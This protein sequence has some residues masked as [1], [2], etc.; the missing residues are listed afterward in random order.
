M[1]SQ[2]RRVLRNTVVGSLV[3]LGAHGAQA[4]LVVGVFDPDFGGPLAGTNYSG[5]A[6]FSISQ[7]CL[8]LNLPSIGLFIPSFL[9]CGSGSS[10]MAF[11]GAHVDFTGAET[12]SVDFLASAND[13]L[14]MYV[15][16]HQVIGVWSKVIGPATST[17]PGNE[18]FDLLF[19][20]LFPPHGNIFPT[21]FDGDL[22][23]FLAAPFQTASLFL[24]SEGCVPGSANNGC[25]QSNP[26]AAR[27]VPEPNSVA[28]VLGALGIA[29]LVGLKRRRVPRAVRAA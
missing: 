13:I 10:G 8:D 14:G 22:G 4:T 29:G 23:D 19:G 17:L 20:P 11:L 15:R 1:L 28:L 6:T 9:S 26:A 7:S 16:D 2:I 27:F 5:S 24:V 21:M 3:A 25:L 12:G 18:Q